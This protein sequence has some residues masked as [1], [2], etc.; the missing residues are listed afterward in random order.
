MSSAGLPGLDGIT[1]FSN[2][3]TLVFFE[4]EYR[5]NND[6]SSIYNQGWFN[7]QAPWDSSDIA[8]TGEWDYNSTEGWDPSTTIPGYTEWTSSFV[9]NSGIYSYS[10]PN[11]RIGVWTINIDSDNYVR[12]IPTQLPSCT[13]GSISGTTLT[14]NGTVTATFQ[15][16]MM[17]YGTGVKPGTYIVRQ[18]TSTESVTTRRGKRGTYQVS[19]SQSVAATT[20]YQDVTYSDS[21]YVKSGLTYGGTN[22]F[23]DSLIKPGLNYPNY[24]VIPQQLQ[25]PTEGT[26]YLTLTGEVIG[27]YK[28]GVGFTPTPTGVE[29]GYLAG[30]VIPAGSRVSTLSTIFDGNGTAFYDKRDKYTTPEQG[31][32]YLVFPS[33]NVFE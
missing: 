20:F 17:I 25:S 23:Y 6:I 30:P 7:N 14:V 29:L 11:Q 1:E 12:L 18:L 32:S 13:V 5:T 24:S 28:L 4:Q 8:D 22:I 26:V 10:R 15:P 2:G 19:I 33:A 31:D 9:F 16:G 27:I 3:Q 21:L